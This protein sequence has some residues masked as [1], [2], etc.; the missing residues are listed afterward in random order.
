MFSGA[1]D[2]GGELLHLA[3]TAAHFPVELTVRVISPRLSSRH[4]REVT[5][6]G[7]FA[8][9]RTAIS[10]WIEWYKAARPHRALGYRS[11]RQFRGLQHQLV[12]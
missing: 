2:R 11:L 10:K 1:P 12:A 8:E 6:Y 9:A 3:T 5:G 4:D 7:H